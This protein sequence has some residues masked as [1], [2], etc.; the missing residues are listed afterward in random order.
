MRIFLLKII[1]LTILAS[2]PCAGFLY[3]GDLDNKQIQ[4]QKRFWESR[5]D[6]DYPD[7]RKLSR[8]IDEN[9][10]LMKNMN[11]NW[12]S[13]GPFD[14][15]ENK[16]KIS[17]STVGLGRINA[18][19]FSETD[20]NLIWAGSASGG[21]WKSINGGM[22]WNYIKTPFLVTGISDIKLSPNDDNLVYVV[23]GDSENNIF[24][25]IY[26]LGVIYSENGGVSWEYLD[27]AS[28]IPRAY[29]YG[30]MIISPD[31]N[32]IVYSGDGIFVGN[33]SSNKKYKFMNETLFFDIEYNPD[34]F[35]KQYAATRAEKIG[36]KLLVNILSTDDLWETA[37][38]ILELEN[39]SRAEIAVCKEKPDDVWVLSA[40]S[41]SKGINSLLHSEDGGKSWEEIDIGFD[42][43]ESQGSYNLDIAVSGGGN[44]IALG[45][46]N[47]AISYDRG[48]T[49]EESKGLH[50][51]FHELRFHPKTKNLWAGNDG[52][53]YELVGDDFW[54]FRSVGMNIMQI[55]N[56]SSSP[57]NKNLIL[58]G[59]Q[60]NGS[61]RY[62]YDDWSH[63]GFGD[64]FS[65]AFS[66]HDPRNS[67]ISSQNENYLFSGNGGISYNLINSPPFKKSVT[68]SSI[69]VSPSD[70]IF[71]F[72][73]ELFK[74]DDGGES[75]DLLYDFENEVITS[76]C[77]DPDD[78]NII[79]LSVG[80]KG[81][82]FIINIYGDKEILEIN[83]ITEV[84][85]RVNELVVYQSNIFGGTAGYGRNNKI[86]R[87]SEINNKYE[88]SDYSLNLPD[89]P[90]NSLEIAL[91]RLMI[92]TDI[93]LFELD[94]NAGVSDEI[95]YANNKFI[96]SLIVSD[97]NFDEQSGYL[98]LSSFGSGVWRID[99]GE[100][101]IENPIISDFGEKI[102]CENEELN[103]F[104]ENEEMFDSLIWSNSARGESLEISDEREIYL[105]GF[106][107]GCRSESELLKV[108]RLESEEVFISM[109]GGDVECEGDTILL[110]ANSRMELESG[111]ITWSNSYI[112]KSNYVSESGEYFYTYEDD[113]GGCKIYSDTVEIEFLDLPKVP[114]IYKA[115]N[116]LFSLDKR[117]ID[118][119]LDNSLIKYYSDSVEINST[120]IY[121]G[122]FAGNN[123][124]ESKSIP[125]S[126]GIDEAEINILARGS[127]GGFSV[128]IVSSGSEKGELELFDLFGKKVWQKNMRLR[129]GYFY[130]NKSIS[131]INSGVYFLIYSSENRIKT[132]KIIIY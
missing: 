122:I 47:L 36:N 84:D 51:D 15:D 91:G 5:I 63:I 73:S 102:L 86:F 31:D 46:V 43:V 12:E 40:S 114:K 37:E 76:F 109:F 115:G 64:G 78:E 55:Y 113:G 132:S 7:F 32:S 33:K 68:Y 121:Y 104:I 41:L 82:I 79:Y 48:V 19:A 8:E 27:S 90:V 39:V 49:W 117:P 67:W 126:V 93:G 127:S 56:L 38:V 62:F 34:D 105:T 17:P 124:C 44:I 66:Y 107:D 20:S 110:L 22:D 80:Q 75:W 125:I 45:G 96:S 3:C 129:G 6:V 21:I 106:K 24:P 14:I 95:L 30:K 4:R 9:I 103:I 26:S 29:P 120:G 59:S 72:N 70:V 123:G 69:K 2:S 83:K 111:K 61:S 53:A 101:L 112:G 25:G 99:M 85:R 108:N 57:F 10:L 71:V 42:P 52:G 131:E 92:G 130:E 16:V 13:F 54:K 88:I 18:L 116:K 128:E 65:N 100:C 50:V 35:K 77:F 94:I 1:L 74:S 11:Y 23:T 60:D 28:N 98:F 89:I 97:M 119:F 81:K 118:W 58:V 87:L